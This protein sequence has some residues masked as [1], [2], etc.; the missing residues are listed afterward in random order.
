V[1]PG[2]GAGT[3]GVSD[4]LEQ[5]VEWRRK[6]RAAAGT[7]DPFEFPSGLFFLA[8]ISDSSHPARTPGLSGV[9][10]RGMDGQMVVKR[11]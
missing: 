11:S 6:P 4:G 9:S 3:A 8:T 2:A 7:V 1:A 5:F 10:R